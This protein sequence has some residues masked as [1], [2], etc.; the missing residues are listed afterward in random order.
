MKM[1][2]ELPGLWRKYGLMER[3]SNSRG[4]ILTNPESSLIIRANKLRMVAERIILGK[5]QLLDM[6]PKVFWK[7]EK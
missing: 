3:S 5:C 2:R 6:L 7:A 1:W 4:H